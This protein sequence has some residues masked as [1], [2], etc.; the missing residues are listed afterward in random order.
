MRTVWT[1][2]HHS[3]AAGSEALYAHLGYAE[4]EA[5]A[6]GNFRE[7]FPEQPVCRSVSG[8]AADP[9][10]T[11]VFSGRAIKSME[12]VAGRAML[13]AYGGISSA[14][15]DALPLWTVSCG[16]GATGEGETVMAIVL[17]APD[18]EQALRTFIDRF[19]PYWARGATAEEGVAGDM[20]TG[21]LLPDTTRAALLSGAVREWYA[22]LHFNSS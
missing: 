8:I 21:L 20:I 13:D 9:A 6:L 18:K 16:Y 7:R 10:V 3:A 14:T 19:D 11:Q 12:N 1:S 5:E 4:S 17:R 2:H 22:Y 15:A